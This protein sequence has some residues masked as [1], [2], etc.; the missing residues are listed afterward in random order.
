MS[1]S[2]NLTD[3]ELNLLRR[4]TLEE[5]GRALASQYRADSPEILKYYEDLDATLVKLADKLLD[6]REK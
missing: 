1:D 5:R 6:M 4:L 2:S 3:L